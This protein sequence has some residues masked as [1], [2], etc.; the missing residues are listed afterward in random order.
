MNNRK[1]ST[2]IGAIGLLVLILDSRTGLLAA[3]E[4]LNLCIITLIPSMFPFFLLSMILTSSLAGRSV[5]LL[6]PL[7]RIT[8]IPQGAESLLAIGLLGG[9]PVGAQN[10]LSAYHQGIISQEDAQR[11]AVFCN[12]AGPAFLFGYLSTVFDHPIYPWIIWGIHIFSAL[13]V[14]S[15]IPGGSHQAIL[16]P[17]SSPL[18]LSQSLNRALRVM[19]QVCGWVILFRVLIGFCERWI[20]WAIPYTIR[21]TLTGLLELSNGCIMLS[22]LPSNGLRMVLSST[23]LGF[24]GICVLMQTNSIAAPLKLGLYLPGKALQACISFLLA[25]QLQFA[26]PHTNPCFI[27]PFVV[28]IVG[29]MGLSLLIFLRKKEI[30]VAIFHN[31]LYNQ[32]S[33]K[34]RRTICSS[35]K[36]LKNPVPTVLSAPN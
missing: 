20:F 27:S 5:R 24:S 35:G 28:G 26:I 17:E 23:F 2:V 13:I 22:N 21:I 15:I 16:L 19:G 18:T 10:V 1:W 8:R 29:I 33:C 12:N 32:A 9:Y 34:K 3:Q 6:F 11:M 4:G 30:P 31:L 7:G 25:Y 36:K 14:G